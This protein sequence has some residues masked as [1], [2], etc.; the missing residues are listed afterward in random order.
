MPQDRLEH[1]PTVSLF[2]NT[3]LRR[4]QESSPSNTDAFEDASSARIAVLDQKRRRLLAEFPQPEIERAILNANQWMMEL[5]ATTFNHLFGIGKSI[6]E[7]HLPT[8]VSRWYH[9]ILST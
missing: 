5:W 4:Q 6:S 2:D 9:F 7:Q 1:A 8:Q 3:I